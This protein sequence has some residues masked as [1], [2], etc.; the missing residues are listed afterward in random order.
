MAGSLY[1]PFHACNREESHLARRIAEA[2]RVVEVESS[3][4]KGRHASSVRCFPGTSSGLI[5][6][7][8]TRAA[9]AHVGAELAR[10]RHP[11]DEVLDE[12]PWA[13][14]RS[15]CSETCGPRPR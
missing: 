2:Q 7:S 5:S 13:R 15:R 4:R 11:G 10:L 14:W 1:L 12:G 3:A 9:R 6:V 8:R